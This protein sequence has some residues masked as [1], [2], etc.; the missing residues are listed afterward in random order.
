MD[1]IGFVSEYTTAGSS[2][3][4]SAGKINFTDQSWKVWGTSMSSI[5]LFK[6]EILQ[7]LVDAF[8]LALD[9]VGLNILD[10]IIPRAQHCHWKYR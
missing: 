2:N 4:I 5:S 3:L 1:L 9:I 7:I 6:I 8:L 10:S